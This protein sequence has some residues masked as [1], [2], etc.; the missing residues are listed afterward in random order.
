ME[1]SKPITFVECDFNNAAHLDA[2]VMLVN[3]YIQDD[4]GGGEIVEGFQ[5]LKLVDGLNNHPAKYIIFAIVENQAVGLAIC[6]EMFSTFA[7]KP[8]INI[9]DLIVKKEF[10]N[11]GIG[12]GLLQQIAFFA[13]EKKCSKITLEVREDNTIAHILYIQQG[14]KPCNPNM[15]FWQKKL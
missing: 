1:Q 9:H 12:T 11:H 6:F 4:M 7:Q 15:L 2:L 8:T 3:E 14:F 13:T 10:R 5:K